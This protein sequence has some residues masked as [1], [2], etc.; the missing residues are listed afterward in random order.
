MIRISIG[1]L[2]VFDRVQVLLY[3]S[4]NPCHS[5]STCLVMGSKRNPTTVSFVAL[6][7]FIF[8]HCASHITPASSSSFHGKSC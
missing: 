5:L 8:I 2:F 1:C 3:L 7:G 6:A 4:L